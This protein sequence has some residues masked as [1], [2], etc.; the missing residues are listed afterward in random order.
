MKLTRTEKWKLLPSSENKQDIKTTVALSSVC[1]T[2]W[3]ELGSLSSKDA[4]TLVEHLIH[5]TK[6]RP[7]VKYQ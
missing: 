5:P 3:K 2:H 7:K 1:L 6:Q 4:M